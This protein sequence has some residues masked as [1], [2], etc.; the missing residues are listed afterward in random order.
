MR[1]KLDI[2]QLLSDG[3]QYMHSNTQLD[4]GQFVTLNI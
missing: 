1:N 2:L 3:S 4:T